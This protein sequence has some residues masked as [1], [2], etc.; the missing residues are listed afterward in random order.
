M[1]PPA[2]VL[3]IRNPDAAHHLGLADI[4]RRDPLDDLLVVQRRG[5]HPRPPRLD[6][7]AAARRSQGHKWRN[8]ILVLEATLNGPRSGSRRPA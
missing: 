5:E 1:H 2:R 7:A 6:R 8:P 3:V 4:Q